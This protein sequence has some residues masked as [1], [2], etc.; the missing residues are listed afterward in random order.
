[1]HLKNWSL[2]YPDG[3]KPVLSPACDL[4]STV[5]YIPNERL[6]L[7][8]AGE[9]E[10]S[11]IDLE[12]FKKFADKAQL[13]EKQTLETVARVSDAARTTWTKIKR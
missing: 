13:P 5:P 12:R 11:A 9:K 3:K 6:A 4:V 8:L 10:F 1:M 2:L 7:I